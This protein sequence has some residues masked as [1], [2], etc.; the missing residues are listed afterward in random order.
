MIWLVIAAWRLRRKRAVPGPAAAA[1]VHEMLDA[2][3][4]AAIQII[5]EERTG[6]RD[7]EDRDGN[8]P[9]LERPESDR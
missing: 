4:R 7:P 2:E 5:L 6:Q 8:L 9:E 1:M 3:K